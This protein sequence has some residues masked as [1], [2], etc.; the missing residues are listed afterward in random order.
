MS[1][2]T[3]ITNAKSWALDIGLG[4]LLLMTVAMFSTANAHS[5][6]GENDNPPTHQL[7]ITQH[8]EAESESI[9]S[10]DA[11]TGVDTGTGNGLPP[12]TQG[13]LCK[14]TV[15]LPT[16][17]GKLQEEHTV[18]VDPPLCL[19]FFKAVRIYNEVLRQYL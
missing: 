19:E 4:V 13:R 6:D 14:L 17:D 15:F 12:V 18:V 7:E 10:V 8:E 3:M 5:V 2:K 9:P 1:K 16:A 11:D